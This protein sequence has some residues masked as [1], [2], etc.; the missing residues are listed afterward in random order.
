MHPI[1]DIHALI[2]QAY[3]GEAGRSDATAWHGPS[4][5]KVLDGVTTE[6]ALARPFAGGHN[7]WEL[8]LHIAQWDSI[9]ARRLRGESIPTTTGDSD[10]WPA[11][12][13]ADE[14]SWQATLVRLRRSQEELLSEVEK[15]DTEDLDK[16]VPGW[17]WTNYLMIHGTLH[18]D[19]YHAGQIAIL[20]RALAK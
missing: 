1:H 11:L 17:T 18:H 3:R 19:L 5:D 8:V 16:Q 13:G 9:C 14:P 7:I 20:R 12:P 2:L 15:L 4:L 6:M 10:D